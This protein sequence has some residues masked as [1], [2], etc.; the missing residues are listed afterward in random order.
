MSRDESCDIAITGMAGRFPGCVGLDDWWSAL[1]DGRVLTTRYERDEL[2]AAGIGPATLEDPSYVPVR[3]HLDGADR[4]DNTLF[5]ISGREAELM[6]PQHR[7]MLEVAWE[8]LEEAATSPLEEEVVTGVYASMTGS[9]YMRSMLIN[10]PLD[11]AVLDDV[12]HGTEPDFVASRIAY[13]LGLTGPAM[14]VQTACSSSLVA[15]HL[16]VQALLNGDC[17][18]AVVVAAG[19]GFPQAGHLSLPGG[20]LSASGRCRPFDAEADGTVA[21]SGVASVVLRRLG[22]AGANTPEPH[23]VIIGTAVNNDGRAKA[24]YY[25]PSAIRQEDVIVAAL[26]CA[27]VD[28]RSIGYLETHG[29]GTRV[30]D[31]IEWSAASAAL[32]RM[33]AAAGQIAVGAVKANI[34]HLDAASGLAGLIKALLVVR[35]GVIP[36]MAGFD[37]LNPLLGAESSPLYVPTK[38]VPWTGDMARRACV[39]SFG[40]GGTNAHVVIEQTRTAATRASQSTPSGDTGQRGRLTLLSASDPHALSRLAARVGNHLAAHRPDIRDVAFTLAVGR[41]FLPERLAVCGHDSADVA[42]RLA[43]GSGVV[44]ARRP[45]TGPGPVVLLFPGQGAQYGGMAEPYA[46]CLPGFD[47]ALR[48]CLDA[49]DGDIAVT[50]R[51]ALLDRAPTDLDPTELAQPA[52]F[53]VQYAAATALARMGVQPVGLIGHSLGEITAIC[54]AGALDLADAARLVV[55]RGR[56]M[57]ACP[58]G[59]MLALMCGAVE[60][61][62]LV[63]SCGA[64]LEIAALNGPDSCVLAGTHE[65]ISAFESW[66][67]DRVLFRRLRTSHAFHSTLVEPAVRPL[68]D[69][70]SSVFIRPLKVALASTV[71]GDILPAGATPERGMLADQIRRPVQFGRAMTAIAK[72]FPGAVLVDMGPGRALTTA[73]EAPGMAV[74]PLSPSRRALAADETMTALGTLWAMG[75]PI[76]ARALCP[77]GVRI[78]LP[79][80]PFAGPSWVAAEIT[81]GRNGNSGLP[82]E[83]RPVEVTAAEAALPSEI[84]PDAEQGGTP[85]DDRAPAA[86]PRTVIASAWRDLLGCEHLTGDA[87][88]IELG[89]DS[90]LIT[91]LARRVNQQLGIRVSVRSMFSARTLSRQTATVQDLVAERDA[92]R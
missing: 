10:G 28:G 68:A 79:T 88:F 50:L 16:A 45:A 71:T 49:Y 75:L 39:S 90:L 5:R 4:F 30:G 18:Q 89:G 23:G 26:L 92:Q 85:A 84:R 20:V 1:V 52:I 55:A 66:L 11:A 27:G 57:Q 14:A 65:A 58:G 38:A 44:R 51:R 13:K 15:V 74:V 86:D 59:A 78:H 61:A 64:A 69:E 33:G 2:L 24:G 40:I 35:R 56:A 63:A 36:P 42:Q 47:T 22:D 77:D 31:P 17:D 32:A 87:D 72:R 62:R 7:L 91:R 6:D 70:L 76:P 82:D 21:G 43:T 25:A 48:A 83:M 41:A 29:T 12:I 60:A 3:G 67:G 37:G 54:V 19:V 46:E 73:V 34:G 81:R 80:Y 53:A 9:G 8:A